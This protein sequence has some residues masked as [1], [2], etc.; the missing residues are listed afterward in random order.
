MGYGTTNDLWNIQTYIYSV[1]WL[2]WNKF[3]FKTLKYKLDAR[4]FLK[5]ET[6]KHCFY[7]KRKTFRRASLV[8][9][10]LWIFFVLQLIF[11][12]FSSDYIKKQTLNWIKVWDVWGLDWYQPTIVSSLRKNATKTPYIKCNNELINF[13]KNIE[14]I[15]LNYFF[16]RNLSLILLSC[17][18]FCI[19]KTIKQ[20]ESEENIF[21][22]E[23]STYAI[24]KQFSMKTKNSFEIIA[25]RNRQNLCRLNKRNL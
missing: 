25:C 22:V 19:F 16:Q 10:I 6:R 8:L 20:L 9:L 12:R 4:Y 18:I 14:K 11:Y 21:F 2:F 17:G 7:R 15:V 5:I 24:E 3:K 23:L 13:V 1:H